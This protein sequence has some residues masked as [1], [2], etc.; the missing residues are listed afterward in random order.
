MTWDIVAMIA[1]V[2]FVAAVLSIVVALL[3]SVIMDAKTKR[4]V[5]L[6]EAGLVPKG[7]TVK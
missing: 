2:A 7:W 4:D 6:W 3:V 1:V 5:R